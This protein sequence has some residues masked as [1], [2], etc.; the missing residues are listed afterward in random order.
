MYRQIRYKE[1]GSYDHYLRFQVWF[2]WFRIPTSIEI[3][4]VQ[5]YSRA[6]GRYTGQFFCKKQK[7]I[8]TE[9][10]YE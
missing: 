5:V 7:K 10:I 1:L 9:D 2:N 3:K 4:R 6:P 8:M